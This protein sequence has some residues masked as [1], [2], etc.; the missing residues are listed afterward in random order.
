MPVLWPAHCACTQPPEP[1]QEGGAAAALAAGLT[2][3]ELGS[4]IGASI[5]NPAHY[6]GV[7]GHKP[8][9]GLVPTAGHGSPGNPVELDIGVGGPLARYAADL[10]LGLSVVA[11]ADRLDERVEEERDELWP[12]KTFEPLDE[13]TP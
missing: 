13:P 3:L 1:N 9:Y 6:C 5:R 4:D 2:A 7:F 12:R 10:D 11:G 8:T